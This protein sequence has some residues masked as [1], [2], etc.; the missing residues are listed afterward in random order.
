MQRAYLRFY[1]ELNDFLAA[2]RRFREFEYP[3][4]VSGSVKDVI[5]SAGVP[6]TEVDLVLVNGGSQGFDYRVRNGDRISV[7]PVFEAF[8][9]RSV[10][11]LRSE[12]LRALRFVLDTHLGKLARYLRMAGFDAHYRND[13][14][15]A[16]LVRISKAEHRI[17]LT[18]DVGL[19]KHSALTHA[20]FV[21]ETDPRRQ[22][23]GILKRFDL[24][25]PAAA[26]SR[27]LECNEPLERPDSSE[28]HQCPACGRIYWKGSHYSR[29]Q[30]FLAQM[31][32]QAYPNSADKAPGI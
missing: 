8:D 1:A 30:S 7:Y 21:R 16:E 19:L 11:R 18:R 23:V 4:Y 25:S 3:F 24:H 15:D 32:K 20:S 6:H 29:M 5:E 13:S 9:I 12:P 31:F 10:S 14:S 28:F 17:L 2:E 26:F 22:F 27:C